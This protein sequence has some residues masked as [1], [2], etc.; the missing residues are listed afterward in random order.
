[1]TYNPDTYKKWYAKNREEKI[2][3]VS[4]YQKANRASRNEYEKA[5]YRSI[6]VEVL[7]YYGGV[8]ACCGEEEKAFLQIDHINGNGNSHRRKI[9]KESGG[10]VSMVLWLKRNNFPAGFQVLCANCN[11]AKHISGVCPHELAES[12]EMTDR[13]L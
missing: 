3:T 2:A 6:R 9:E 8:C 4:A 7:E 12:A 1:M 11:M 10:R 13:L 5:R